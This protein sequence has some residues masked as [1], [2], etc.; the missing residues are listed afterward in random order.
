MFRYLC[1][2]DAKRNADPTITTTTTSRKLVRVETDMLLKSIEQHLKPQRPLVQYE[3]RQPMPDCRRYSVP[4]A[5]EWVGRDNCGGVGVCGVIFSVAVSNKADSRCSH[6]PFCSSTK[7]W[8]FG[9]FLHTCCDRGLRCIIE[10][11]VSN[12]RG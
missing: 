2:S 1:P 7:S 10:V 6:C 5:A 8:T 11:M 3:Q 12:S 9:D 4:P